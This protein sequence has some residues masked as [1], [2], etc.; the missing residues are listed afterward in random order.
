MTSFLCELLYHVPLLY[1]YTSIVGAKKRTCYN[2]HA[3]TI[4]KRKKRHG[5]VRITETGSKR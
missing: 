5:R 2:S 3:V 4:R 1:V